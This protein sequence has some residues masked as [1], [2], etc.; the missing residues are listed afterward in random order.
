MKK[1]S[2]MMRGR[3]NRRLNRRQRRD[4]PYDDYDY[5]SVE[6]FYYILNKRRNGIM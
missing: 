4:H 3:E 1:L 6:G 2:E 5:S